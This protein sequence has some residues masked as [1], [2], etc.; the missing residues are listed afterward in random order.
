MKACIIHEVHFQCLVDTI[1]KGK[2]LDFKKLL[3]E[4]R[5]EGLNIFE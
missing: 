3:L 5:V 1:S 2:E 4:K